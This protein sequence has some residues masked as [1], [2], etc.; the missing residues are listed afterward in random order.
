MISVHPDSFHCEKG[1]FCIHPLPQA[2]TGRFLGYVTQYPIL[3]AFLALFLATTKNK[4]R[5]TKIP[6]VYHE[7]RIPQ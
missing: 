4:I 6:H 7:S 2:L 1:L 3:V 5:K